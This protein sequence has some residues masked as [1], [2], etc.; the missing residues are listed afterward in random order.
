MAGQGIELIARGACVVRG[1]LLVCHSRGA[2]NTFLPGGHVEFGESAR[3]ALAREL[4]E[5]LGLP[6][7]VGPFLG[8]VEHTFVQRRRRH[9]ELNLVFGVRIAGVSP[10][11]A[12]ASRE[13]G[14]DFRWMRLRDAARSALEPSPLRECLARWMRGGLGEGSRWRTTFRGR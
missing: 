14:L 13:P 4:E 1:A 3:R 12:P 9:C 8:A 6:C 10:P 2:G 7:R 11:A 5:E